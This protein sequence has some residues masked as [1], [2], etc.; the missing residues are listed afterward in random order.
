MSE[1]TLIAARGTSRVDREFLRTLPLP[2]V[3]RTHKPVPHI[4]VVQALIETLAFRH[5]N[6]VSDEYAVTPDG[7]RCFGL[8]E[9]EHGVQGVHFAIGLR[10]AHDKSMRLGLTVGYRV[11]VCSNLAFQGEFTPTLVKHS[12]RM[13][14][15]D[16]VSIGV[17]RIQR[18][19]EPLTREIQ[20]FHEIELTDLEA[21]GLFYDAFLDRNLA[22][23]HALLPAVHHHYFEP[24]IEDFQPRTLWSASNSFTSAFKQMKP[25]QQFQATA[26]LGTFIEG[27]NYGSQT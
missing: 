2:E 16:T 21:K 8:I 18:G 3:T 13:N 19:F 10:N 14:L 12:A 22:L 11:L 6:V 24:E 20:T 7:M 27:R 9:L 23:P 1:S 4:E 5:I 26:R 25:V 15:I 17:D